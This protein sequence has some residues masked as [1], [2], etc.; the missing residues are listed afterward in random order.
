MLF[1]SADPEFVKCQ[2]AFRDFSTT[3]EEKNRLVTELEGDV[4]RLSDSI[5]N[6]KLQMQSL[7]RDLDKL[8]EEKP[9]AVADV[10]S[11]KEEQSIADTL[12]G[13]SQDRTDEELQGLRELRNKAKASATISKELAG[14]DTK[15]QEAEFMAAVETSQS[16][17]EFDSLIFGKKDAVAAEAQ[18]GRAHV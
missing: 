5:E 3:L 18:I 15:R 9:E 6:H 4:K 10:I 12:N 14:T 1:R 13:L 16:N 2:G 8:K 11:A 7:M 17:S